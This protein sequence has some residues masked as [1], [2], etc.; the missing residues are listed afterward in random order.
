MPLPQGSFRVD[1]NASVAEG[2]AVTKIFTSELF[3]DVTN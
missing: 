1:I 2:D 3:F